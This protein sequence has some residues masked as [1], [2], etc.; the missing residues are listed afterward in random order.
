MSHSVLAL[1]YRPQKFAEVKGQD[2]I[3]EILN[4]AL[5]SKT[6]PQA[7]I[8]SGIRGTGKTTIARLIAKAINCENFLKKDVCGICDNCKAVQNN[9]HLDVIEIDGASYTG[10]DN[11]R[12]IIEASQY[13]AIMGKYRVFIVDEVHML[14][15]SAFNAL[16]KNLEEPTDHTVYIL[17]TTEFHKIPET[18]Q[19]RCMHCQTNLFSMSMLVDIQK[20]LLEKEGRKFEESALYDIAG[21]ADGSLR[22]A[23]TILNQVLL[24]ENNDTLKASTVHS[25]LGMCNR[26][27]MFELLEHLLNGDIENILIQ[28]RYMMQKGAVGNSILSQLMDLIYWI[29]CIKV[30]PD[31]KLSHDYPEIDRSKGSALADQVDFSK[32]HMIWQ[33]LQK[34]YH[35]FQN[36]PLKTPTLEMILMR[37]CFVQDVDLKI[38]TFKESKST[39][40]MFPSFNQLLEFVKRKKEA[41]LYQKL[42]FFTCLE[43]SDCFLK[44]KGAGDQ[45]IASDIAVKLR[46]LTGKNWQVSI[47]SEE[48]LSANNPSH[49]QH[50]IDNQK[51]SEDTPDI[52]KDLAKTFPDMEVTVTKVE[53]ES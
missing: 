6:L 31:L 45:S 23:Q 2:H 44:L 19:S 15:K 53:K 9:N 8:L 47:D 20:N 30:S 11:I 39:E 7:I 5:E 43:I 25:I 13:K 21:A 36:T 38:D 32:L 48:G 46:K 35:E 16:L 17:A 1:K 34:G 10:I 41:V 26:K 49:S 3:I 29:C 42:N 22:D 14:S 27:D 40:P 51:V 4:Q 18:I 50:Q 12:E 52:I 28:V 24:L 33:V 37:V